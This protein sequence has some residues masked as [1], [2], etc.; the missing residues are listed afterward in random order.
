[1]VTIFGMFLL[2]LLPIIV[3]IVAL[4]ALKWE[5]YAAALSALAVTIVEALFI[6]HMP[7]LYA[8]T[9]AAEGFAMALWPISIVIIA[10]VWV[11]NLTVHSGAMEVI[12]AQLMGVSSDKRVLVILIAWCFGGF[13]EGMAGFGSAV[14]IPA[15]MLVALGLNPVTAILACL[16]SNGVPTMF[17]SIGIPTNTLASITGLDVIQLS[18]VQVIQV[19]P[20]V[21]LTPFLVCIVAG[22][23]PKALKGMVPLL[24]V[25]SLSFLGAE[26]VTASFIGAD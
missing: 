23:G 3:L 21:I 11:Y 9:A 6:W 19:A 2:A 17:G 20:F 18:Q 14:A 16:L 26:F 5:A 13:L 10:A 15:S 25:T 8:A 24:L 4:T 1:M 7:A 12:K 22:G